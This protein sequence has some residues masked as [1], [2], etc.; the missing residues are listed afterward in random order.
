MAQ[1]CRQCARVNPAEAFYCYFDGAILDGHGRV[2]SPLISGTKPFHNLFV[3][4]SGRACANFDQLALAC[5]ELW[6][7]A[8]Q[9]LQQGYLESFL[10]GLGRTDLALAAREAS[11]FPDPDRGL[12][13]FLSKLPTQVVE[14]PKLLVTPREVNLGQLQAGRDHR[15]DLHLANQGMGLLYGTV[16]CQNAIWLGLGELPGA[17]RKLFQLR[18]E[19]VIPIHVRGKELRAGSKP[20]EA[21][22]L[23]ESNG[24]TIPVVLRAEV[25]V[26]PFPD[27]VL[28]GAVTPRKIA[29]KAKAAPKEAALLFENGAVARWYEENGWTYPVQGPSASGIGAVQQF[30]EALGLTPPPKVEISA[31]SVNFCGKI[32][33][34]LEHRLEVR[35]QEKRPVYAH[36]TSDQPWLEVGRPRLAG[37][38]A[39]I[40]LIVPTVPNRPGE[41]LQAKVLITANGNQRFAVPVML[42]VAG[43]DG[44]SL[45]PTVTE[46]SPSVRRA[47]PFA[48]G[49]GPGSEPELIPTVTA[50]SEDALAAVPVATLLPAGR[51]DAVSAPPTLLPAERR[52]GA[53]A[54]PTLAI[55]V[56]RGVE[57]TP[58]RPIP[59]VRSAPR[60]GPP[61]VL[62]LPPTPTDALWRALRHL[63]PA[64]F[65]LLLVCA[66]VV[67]DMFVNG[68]SSDAVLD[69]EPEL[70]DSRPRIALQFHDHDERIFL[71]VGGQIKPVGDLGPGDNIPAT[72]EASMRFGLVALDQGESKRLTFREDGSTNNT[73]VSLDGNEWLFGERPWLTNT[74]RLIPEGWPGRWRDR[75]LPLDPPESRSGRR[76]IGKQSVWVYDN[77]QVVITQV[78]KIVP[79]EQSRLL[80]TCLVRYV[81]ENQDRKAHRVGLRFLLDT[82]IGTNDG[83]P[84]LVPPSQPGAKPH[85]CDDHMDFQR[86]EEI[87]DFIQALE[88]PENLSSPGTVA[89]VQ[90]KLGGRIEPPS[91]VT[92][93]AWPNPALSYKDE[94]CRQERT[95]WEVPVLP[96]KSLTPADS[97]VVIYWNPERLEPGQ[98]REVG[99][100]YG[101]GSVS[102][103]EGGGKLAVTVGGSFTPGGEFTVTAYVQNPARGQ[104]VTLEVPDG[105]AML[106]DEKQAVP[107]LEPDAS[108]RNSPVT[109]KVKA[110]PKTGTYTLTVRSSTGATQTQR[111]KIKSRPGFLD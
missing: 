62:D 75:E 29:E 89:H 59:P 58:P 27:G 3:F 12:D 64:G 69:D 79:G 80:D 47:V 11:H 5:Q 28:A 51:R 94:R 9:L 74:G 4:P 31:W 71:R 99:F 72:W 25:P 86:T 77:E 26:K 111:V 18:G 109:W 1:T 93:G 24:G 83:V 19:Q 78:V 15:L 48:P 41:V 54:P 39:T 84:F 100:A 96:I 110:G 63:L 106:G 88:K 16:S 60:Q 44:P 20:L 35:T 52:D 66:V 34:K 102:S 43:S 61:P 56:A 108:S 46:A 70:L 91:R 22:L 23:V 76:F 37:R 40:P 104:T 85:L 103:G 107:P 98:K 7:E 53:A 101:L 21:T 105:F 38:I 67:H 30:F 57:A 17:Q 45:I 65:L 32:G 42:A 8:L 55:P 50:V 10:G 14:A 82:Y 90:L 49:W 13:Q 68:E 95:M 36:A 92:L 81:I 33:A 87:P 2:A 6:P 97:A 73:C